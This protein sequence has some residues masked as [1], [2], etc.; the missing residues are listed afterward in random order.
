MSQARVKLSVNL[1]AGSELRGDGHRENHTG[2]LCSRNR[3]STS[4]EV[5][6]PEQMGCQRGVSEGL[7]EA[8][9]GRDQ[10]GL[11]LQRQCQVQAIVQALTQWMS[12]V[13]CRSKE[14]SIRMAVNSHSSELLQHQ[15]R[16]LP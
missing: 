2:T 9:V 13:Q 1:L 6:D 10:L 15:V 8:L 16:I 5:L 12:E 14:P 3:A 4:Q 11:E 7:A